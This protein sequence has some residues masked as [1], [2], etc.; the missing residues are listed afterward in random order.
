MRAFVWGWLFFCFLLLSGCMA[1]PLAEFSASIP[2]DQKMTS[3]QVRDAILIAMSEEGWSAIEVN[4]GVFEATKSVGLQSAVVYIAY[5]YKGFSIEYADSTNM[6]YN[7]E[8]DTISV[9]YK[10]WVYALYS[11][12]QYQLHQQKVNHH[13]VS[14]F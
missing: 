14:Q 4:L 3:T 8:N 5:G 1:P 9:A 2:D 6:Q 11:S 7:A 13:E 12:I 10:T